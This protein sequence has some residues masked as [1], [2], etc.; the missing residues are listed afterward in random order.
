MVAFVVQ[1]RKGSKL[2]VELCVKAAAAA[3][4]PSVVQHTAVP[5]QKEAAPGQW[6]NNS[7]HFVVG[8]NTV[9]HGDKSSA[10]MWWFLHWSLVIETSSACSVICC[11]G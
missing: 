11:L 1:Q 8:L 4:H 6:V 9:E 3:L 7:L 10:V 5:V 2:A